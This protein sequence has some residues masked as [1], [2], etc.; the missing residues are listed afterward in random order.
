MKHLQRIRKEFYD[1]VGN[2]IIQDI[3]TRLVKQEAEDTLLSPEEIVTEESE[4]GN[5]Q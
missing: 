2:K 4:N 3:V 1:R 5:P